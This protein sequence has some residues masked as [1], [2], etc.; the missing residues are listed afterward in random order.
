MIGK[1]NV[2]RLGEP[3]APK[4]G[5]PPAPAKSSPAALPKALARAQPT[6]KTRTATTRCELRRSCYVHNQR[7]IN[8]LREDEHSAFLLEEMRS[9]ARFGRMTTLV[10]A[11]KVDLSKVMIAR[12][13]SREQRVKSDGSIELR[14]VDDQTECGLNG[15]TQVTEKLRSEHIDML[16]RIT[17]MI[18][19][20]TGSPLRF[21]KAGID[22]A[23]RRV[24]IR[25]C[26]R[27]FAWVAEKHDGQI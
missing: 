26:D 17:A 8:S 5:K 22:A 13:L 2:S 18:W 9:D 4:T 12:R 15:A 7:P 6:A 1:F 10:L 24:P 20:Q 23:F 14:A 19:G 11:S 21:W 3:L 16:L 27:D 25:P